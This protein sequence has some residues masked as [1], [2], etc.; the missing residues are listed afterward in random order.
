VSAVALILVLI[1]AC[2]HAGWNLLAKRLGGGPAVVWLYTASS[3]LVYAPLALAV[4]LVDRPQIGALELGFMAGTAVLHACYFL[5]LQKG[6]QTSDLSLVYPLARGTGPLLASLGAIVLFGERPTPVALA[7]VGL[8]TLGALSLA[9]GGLGPEAAA[10]GLAF[11]LLTGVLIAAYTLWDKHAVDALAIPPL[12]YDWG[13]NVGRTLVLLPLGVTRRGEVAALWRT[14]RRYVLGIGVLSSL[15]Y[16]LVLTA[17]A[18]TPVTYVAPTREVSIVIG[19]LLGT[20]VLGE[21]DGS[22]RLV[23]AITI[24]IGVFALGIG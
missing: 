8:V 24:V 3:T 1:S 18:Y 10:S 21:G 12:L 15:A 7:G 9:R 20:H 4:V 2:A 22:R 11:G 19:T 13:N 23:A 5:S 17:L 6:Y 14:K 16:I